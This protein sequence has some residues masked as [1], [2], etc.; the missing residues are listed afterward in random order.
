MGV[1]ALV[2]LI[3]SAGGKMSAAVWV[4]GV[5]TLAQVRY[6]FG[7]IGFGHTCVP[8]QYKDKFESLKML[9]TKC[10]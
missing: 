5:S 6:L 2:R 10:W 1:A 9:F 3:V 7:I 8:M 4:D